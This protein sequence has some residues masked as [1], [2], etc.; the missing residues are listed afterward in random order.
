[1]MYQIVVARHLHGRGIFCT[2]GRNEPN[3]A[4]TP[5]PTG[6]LVD[7]PIIL[8][9]K[10][11]AK[12]RRSLLEVRN[13]RE[14]VGSLFE[15]ECHVSPTTKESD[16]IEGPCMKCPVCYTHG[17]LRSGTAG[18]YGRAGIAIYDDAF[19]VE[20]GTTETLTLNSVDTRTQRTGQALATETFI[21][22][23]TFL[24]VITLK[25]DAPEILN[26]V[27]DGVVS[28]NSYGARSRHYGRMENVI[29][30]TVQSDRPLLTAYAVAARA[31]NGSDDHLREVVST[32]L[33]AKGARLSD[34]PR[35]PSRVEVMKQAQNHPSVQAWIK[36]VRAY[37]DAQRREKK[38]P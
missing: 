19:C 28:T 23:G 16:K 38:K 9:R 12:E 13:S 25:H 7:R 20:E 33:H 35:L 36:E 26:L 21:Y 5:T 8:G 10:L 15:D 30:G 34:L 11:A 2:E 17:G 3:M 1:M 27:L 18:S 31:E 6:E 14:L 37:L 4:L 24:N 22:G 32:L 29:I